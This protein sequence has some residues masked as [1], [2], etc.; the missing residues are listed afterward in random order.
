MRSD[1]SPRL[2]V[3]PS[4]PDDDQ[5]FAGLLQDVGRGLARLGGEGPESLTVTLGLSL[6][7]RRN[8]AGLPELC[9]ALLQ[10]RLAVLD[11]AGVDPVSEPTPL[12]VRDLRTSALN[13]AHYLCDLL[14]RAAATAATSPIDV[15]EQ[16]VAALS[17]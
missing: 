2:V 16:A 17:A 9:E 1:V 11:A 5:M 8:G 15:A 13:L 4:P 7:M 14:D 10:L 3:L 12:V 6:W